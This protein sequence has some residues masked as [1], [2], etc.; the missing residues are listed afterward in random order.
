[1]SRGQGGSHDVA[2]HRRQVAALLAGYAAWGV[3]WGGWG[4]L[5]PAVQ[6]RAG[7]SDA[8]LGAVLLAVAVGAVPA[9]LAAGALVDRLGG[10]VTAASLVLFAAAIAV[11]G[12]V[13]G[14]VPLALALLLLGAASGAVD[15]ALNARVAGFEAA[16]GRKLFHQAHAVFPLAVVVTSPAVGLA[17]QAGAGPRV[18]LL[19]LAGVALLAALAQRTGGAPPRA[20]PTR[21]AQ[22]GRMRW[23]ELSWPLLALGGF[24]AGIHLVENG[25]EQWSAIFLE[26]DLGAA[27]LVGSL[28][29]GVYM[30]MLFAGRVAIHRWGQGRSER[31]WLGVTG[32]AAALGMGVVCAAP[33][34]G[35]GVALAGFALAGLGMAA[36]IPAIF[37]LAAR[38]A[39]ADRRGAAMGAVTAVAYSG[40][41]LAPPFVGAVAELASLRA[42]WAALGVIGLILLIA[43]RLRRW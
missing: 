26:Q 38:A 16:T 32:A 1:M 3:F 31:L 34:L 8:V 12:W 4:A 18:I 39:P 6:A 25:V 21:R 28:G 35:A 30:G 20:P 23:G 15:V 40:Y 41:L 14:P 43:A 24:G 7:A 13:R 37:G 10:R 33:G 2:G 17:R 9:M 19:A 42:S 11:L 36:G 29:P 5:L 27:P 22:T